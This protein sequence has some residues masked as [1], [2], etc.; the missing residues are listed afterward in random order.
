MHKLKSPDHLIED[1]IA[2]KLNNFC[3]SATP[4]PAASPKQRYK[5]VEMLSHVADFVK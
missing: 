5:P 4:F 1:S 2:M 3:H